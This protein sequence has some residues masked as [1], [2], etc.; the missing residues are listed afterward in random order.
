MELGM[1]GDP[2]IAEALW[3]VWIELVGA[4]ESVVGG[5][6]ARLPLQVAIGDRV[7]QRGC[8]QLTA[9]FGEFDQIVGRERHHLEALL[10]FAL[11]KFLFCQPEQ[12][13]AQDPHARVVLLAQ[14]GVPQA[15]ARLVTPGQDVSP[16]PIEYALRLGWAAGHMRILV[17]CSRLIHIFWIGI[18]FQDSI[19]F[20]ISSSYRACQQRGS[21]PNFG[22]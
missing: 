22:V 5:D 21:A 15:F 14:F 12:G 10:G 9:R 4:A 20:T 8:L 19:V 11:H 1:G 16:E 3:V 7:P 18:E 2:S 13:L 17:I 6:E